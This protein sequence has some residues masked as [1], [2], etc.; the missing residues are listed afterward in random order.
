[1]NKYLN[2]SIIFSM[3][4][5]FGITC[6]I[7]SDLYDSNYDVF[8][9]VIGYFITGISG[10]ILFICGFNIFRLSRESKNEKLLKINAIVLMLGS[11][12][13]IGFCFSLVSMLKINPYL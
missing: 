6:F 5:P 1:M 3:L 13:G 8:L 11:L 4:M 10:F 2:V 7:F 12:G 9:I